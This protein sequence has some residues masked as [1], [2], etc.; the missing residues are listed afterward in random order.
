MLVV[1]QIKDAAK[2]FGIAS[3]FQRLE[4]VKMRDSRLDNF[5]P[6]T[7]KLSFDRFEFAELSDVIL[8]S[9]D[10]VLHH[11]HRCI[12]VSRVEYFNSMLASSWL[13]SSSTAPLQLPIPSSVMS[14]TGLCLHLH[15]SNPGWL[16]RYGTGLQRPLSLRNV[17]QLLEFASIYQAPQ[18]KSS[19]QQFIGLNIVYLLESQS[20]DSLSDDVMV[21][22]LK[23]TGRWL[24]RRIITPYSKAPS[25]N[26]VLLLMEEVSEIDEVISRAKSRRK[27]RRRSSERF[28]QSSESEVIHLSESIDE[29]K[30][31]KT[32]TASSAEMRKVIS[33]EGEEEGETQKLREE[34]Q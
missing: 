20:L 15:H 5:R 30:V 23:H 10:E 32:Q 29:D 21:N 14:F 9:D 31:S 18:L 3:L 1:R 11:C 27:E 33:R 13:E 16:H 4:L 22:L 12:L 7:G 8:E 2:M 26:D 6:D 24:S 34:E 19:C 28:S 25:S 17:S